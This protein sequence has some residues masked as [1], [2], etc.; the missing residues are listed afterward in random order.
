LT[1]GQAVLAKTSIDNAREHFE[2]VSGESTLQCK[3]AEAGGQFGNESTK[4]RIEG[5][6]GIV[7]RV[8]R[9]CQYA[10]RR[11][12]KGPEGFESTRSAR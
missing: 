12:V 4:G 7:R 11:V 1:L 9:P 5:M 10:V 3:F 6:G 8:R 2:Y